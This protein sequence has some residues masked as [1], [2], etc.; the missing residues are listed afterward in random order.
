M[1]GGKQEQLNDFP[2][3]AT[4]VAALKS[5][6]ID[7]AL[8]TTMGAVT[9]YETNKDADFELV[10]D[11]KPFY[12]DANPVV[13]YAAFAFRPQDKELGEAFNKELLAMIRTPEYAELMKK[14]G[15]KASM[16]PPQGAT[17]EE[18]CKE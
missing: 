10:D 13:S 7:V 11:F 4:L 16:L 15:L 14:Y 8:L 17:A 6:R 5:N 12:K 18:A 2:D 9:M 1:A 3:R